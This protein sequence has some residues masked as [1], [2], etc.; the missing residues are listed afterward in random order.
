MNK[1]SHYTILNTRPAAQA[2]SLNHLLHAEGAKVINFPTIE[3]TEPDDTKPA[4]DLLAQ[5]NQ[6]DYAIFVSANAVNF[7][8]HYWQE[9]K[10]QVIAI[11]SGTADALKKAGIKIDFIPS[12]FSSEGLL[13]LDALQRIA[14]KRI[15]IF[16]GQNA[17]QL[18]KENLSLRGATVSECICY[19]RKPPK[20]NSLELSHLINANI[21]LVISTSHE[22]LH[23]LYTILSSTACDWL[24]AIPLLVINSNM[25]ITAQQLGFKKPIIL[26]QNA[27]NAAIVAALI[28]HQ[29]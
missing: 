11:G 6:F 23:N 4:I 5:L 13:R 2:E 16:C 22:S 17:R 26:A 9:A 24:L 1:L 7:V 27:S 3:I 12:D 19:Q 20:I 14:G 25:L 29:G 21:N 8:K 10:A 15:I 18:L 28:K